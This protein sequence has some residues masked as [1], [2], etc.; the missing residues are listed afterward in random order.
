M[1]L[2]VCVLV[3]F[4]VAIP[5]DSSFARC[6]CVRGTL[7]VAQIRG[8]VVATYKQR[9][10][11]E[12]PISGAT[13]KV[14]KCR[15]GECETV[16]E[17]TTDQNGRFNIDGVKPGEYD[18]EATATAFQRIVVGLK[19]HHSYAG[20]GRE[21]AMALEPSADCCAGTAVLRRLKT[22][23]GSKRAKPAI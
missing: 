13:V 14:L 17:A 10:K 21:I 1:K 4:M 18:L 7:K 11:V 5:A 16:A 8:Q 12:D 23:Q 2:L 19:L 3:V 15:D 22:K 20:R 9:P 6:T